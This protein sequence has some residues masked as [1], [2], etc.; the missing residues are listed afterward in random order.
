MPKIGMRI[1]KSAIAVN[2]CCII[3]L[4][5]GGMPFYSSIAAILCMQKESGK[6]KVVAINRMVGTC[7]GGLCGYLALLVLKL[8][9]FTNLY[10]SYSFLSLCIIP[11][12]YL[13]IVLKKQSATYITCVVFLCVTITHGGDVSP[14][15]FALNRVI[16][17]FIGIIVSLCINKIMFEYHEND[18][19]VTSEIKK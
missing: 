3:C 5:R 16:D 19:I 14:Q 2:I 8:P 17:T 11:L 1:I 4:L 18:T 10:I 7:I 9:L 6:A 15:L 12:M 13:T